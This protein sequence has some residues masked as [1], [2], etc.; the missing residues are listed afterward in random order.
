M[1]AG[2]SG[3]TAIVEFQGDFAKLDKDVAAKGAAAGNTFSE[4]FK[5]LGAAVVGSA[6]AVKV[7]QFFQGAMDEAREAAKVSRLTEAAVKSTGGVANVSAEQVG[8]LADRLSKVAG[9]DDE[10]IQGGENMLLTFT[11]VRNAVGAGNN[12]FDQATEAALNMSVAMGTDM[13]SA[14]VMVGKAL[15]DPIQ[16][17][18]A[19]RRVGVQLTDQQEA[20]IKKFVESGDVMSAQ[21]VI[22]G[23]L[24]KEFGGAAAAAASP[25]DKAAV[26]WGNFKERVGTGL[27]P[28]LNSIL[29]VITPLL[30]KFTQLPAPLQTAAVAL[31]GG[32]AVAGPFA[33]ALGGVKDAA[34][35]VSGPLKGAV[36]GIGRLRDG[37]NSAGAAN[38]A[39]SGKM[40]TLG[41]KMR[42]V[43]SS[44]ASGAKALVD[45]GKGALIAAANVAK[46][47][48]ALVA[49]KAA[50]IA[51]A[52]ASKI[53]TAAQWL[54]NA[55]LSAN[56]IGLIVMAIAALVGA[57]IY[58]Y[59]HFDW[60]RNAVNAVWQGIVTVMQWAWNNVIK[61]IWDFI[62]AFIRD[63]LIPAF[64]QY[65]EWAQT[66]W[67]GISAVIQWAWNN[68]IQPIWNLIQSYIRDHLVP[69][70]QLIQA[71]ASAVW[72]GIKN[73]I[74]GAWDFISGIWQSIVNFANT[75]LIPIW[76]V[77]RGAA[78][79]AFNGLR[80]IV[81]SAWGGLVGIIQG[82]VDGIKRV[83]NST[84]GGFGFSVPEWIPGVGGKGFHIP[85]LHTGGVY[86]APFGQT[87]GLALLRDREIVMTPA[88][89]ARSSD[90]RSIVQNFHASNLSAADVSRELMWTLRTAA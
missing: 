65:W 49:Q 32:V 67:N 52:A 36:D 57:V 18:G 2:V 60:F 16:G 90:A 78:E 13:K 69:Q 44:V 88:Q 39:F 23:E 3:G 82:A 12:V 5:R 35:L 85:E 58:A 66:V 20:Q 24:T 42:S 61:P 40:G 70:F 31:A 8:A 63:W 9:I 4:S 79:S 47:T 86:R 77:I 62:V 43:V 72:D 30:D 33:R 84:V 87:E 10:V 45:F 26:A 68:V 89:A 53:V 27:A 28:A 75:Y 54:W 74:S 6:M 1:P 81:E 83:W 51:Q 48:A 71:V 17:V 73:A 64:K 56:P 76:D 34:S 22:L 25:A 55:A 15:N 19:L 29:D 50:A 46:Q 37:F 7:G 14:S 21:K 59:T 38:S 41:G 80:G 11:N